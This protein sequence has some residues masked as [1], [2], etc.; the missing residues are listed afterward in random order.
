MKTAIAA[1]LGALVGA[2]AL[3][4]IYKQNPPGGDELAEV[5]EQLQ[6]A[7]ADLQLS[8]K[9]E[10][11]LREIVDELKETATTPAVADASGL[12]TP[13]AEDEGDEEK[14]P[15]EMAELMKDFGNAKSE[16]A[17]NTL[18]KQL[19]L[20]GAQLESFKAVFDAVSAK[21]QAAFGAMFTGKGTLEDFA[22]M[23]GVT[24][25]I[26]AWADANLDDEQQ[27]AYAEYKAAQEENR[28]E[29]K[30]NEELGWL[31]SVVNLDADQKDAAFQVFAE[32]QAKEPPEG[33][34]E[35]DSIET[36]REQWDA[37]R[38]S[39]V[40]GLTPVLNEDQLEAYQAGTETLTKM[41]EGMVKNALENE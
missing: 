35:I 7:S 33:I 19:G 41:V 39:R 30:A 40:E 23:E 26:D 16:L 14:K 24:T 4:A 11:R 20:E 9:S 37:S 15:N 3:W 27:E 29:R 34:L 21:Q 2:G 13:L 38:E 10:K 36:F 5:R 17:F 25:D 6:I 12:P 31:S 1:I 18:V 28:I 32:H 8:K 22:L